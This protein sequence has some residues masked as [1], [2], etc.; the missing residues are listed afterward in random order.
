MNIFGRI[1]V[2]GLICG[3]IATELPPGPNNFRA[4]LTQRLRMLSL[5]VFDC[6]DRLPETIEQL[7]NWHASGQLK[8][9]E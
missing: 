8:I 4:I 2:C 7:G 9:R 6:N 1:A 3:Y 5:I